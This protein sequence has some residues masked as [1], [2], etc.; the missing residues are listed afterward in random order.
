MATC[1]ATVVGYQHISFRV[2]LGGRDTSLP[3]V[4]PETGRNRAVIVPNFHPGAKVRGPAQCMCITISR[5]VQRGSREPGQRYEAVSC[6][7]R[8]PCRSWAVRTC[9]W[10]MVRDRC[11]LS[12]A[13]QPGLGLAQCPPQAAEDLRRTVEAFFENQFDRFD[14][15][16]TSSLVDQQPC[17]SGSSLCQA[18][19]KH[20]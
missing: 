19:V 2:N 13:R 8:R 1:E 6:V 17:P 20:S 10:L 11:D 7:Q 4:G 18:D 9:E 16:L 12:E 5:M 3:L 14:R 15:D